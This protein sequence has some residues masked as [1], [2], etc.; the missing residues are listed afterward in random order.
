MVAQTHDLVAVE[1]GEQL[2]EE[3]VAVREVA[4]VAG[5]ATD[6]H[7]AALHLVAVAE[8]VPQALIEAVEQ[9]IS[10]VAHDLHAQV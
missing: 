10:G 7:V 6:D 2:V 4:R 9:R 1:D 5:E 3:G 8:L